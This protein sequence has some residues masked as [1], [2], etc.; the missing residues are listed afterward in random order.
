MNRAKSQELNKRGPDGV[1]IG[2]T[3]SENDNKDIR[4]SQVPNTKISNL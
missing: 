3:L 2:A 1:T 4:L